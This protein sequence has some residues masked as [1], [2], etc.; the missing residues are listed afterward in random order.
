MTR[1][2][3][4]AAFALALAATPALADEH[5]MEPAQIVEMADVSVGLN[6]LVCDFCATALKKVFSKQKTVAHTYVDLD[7][8]LL[9]VVFK[10]GES[11]SDEELRKLVK[12]A[13]YKATEIE[14]KTS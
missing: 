13:G 11:M 7:T 5:A 14:R 3:A 12:K 6:G 2:F 9:S 8:K 10:D 1:F 4:T